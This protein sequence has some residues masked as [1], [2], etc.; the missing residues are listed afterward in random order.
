MQDLMVKE[1]NEKEKNKINRRLSR[2]LTNR[3]HKY[4]KKLE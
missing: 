2:F 1:N 3:N 4:L